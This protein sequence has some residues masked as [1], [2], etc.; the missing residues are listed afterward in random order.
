MRHIT[1]TV[2]RKIDLPQMARQSSAAELEHKV[3]HRSS[4]ASEMVAVPPLTFGAL[5]AER[6]EM[7]EEPAGIGWRESEYSSFSPSVFTM[8]DVVVHGSSGIVTY[9]DKFIGD[10][11]EHTD[12]EADGY[13][14]C[15]DGI[16][17]RVREAEPLSCRHISLLAGGAGNF[18]HGLMD[19]VA[20]LSM[21][22]DDLF[23]DGTGILVPG[24]AAAAIETLTAWKPGVRI[25]CV[26]D[27]ETLRV[28]RLVL[29]STVKGQAAYHPCICRLFDGVAAA[30]SRGSGFGDLRRVYIDR[31]GAALR[32]LVNEDELVVA[33]A[34]LGI[35]AVRLEDFSVG[36]QIEMF[37]D[38][39]LI[40]AP[41]GAGLTNLV[42][43]RP[44]CVVLELLMDAYVNWSFRR[45]AAVR[46]V[47]Y[48][49]I[50]GRAIGVWTERSPAVHGMSWVISVGH[51]VAAV[52]DI[53]NL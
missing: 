44:G 9:A 39:E 40:V 4:L 29:P 5:F 3:C 36:E 37:Q 7:R 48:D 23:E 20:R 24:R 13:R 51:V 22:A 49:C 42:Y 21:V 11:L 16:A 30:R 2:F 32:P 33:L 26:A 31:R 1:E 17:L 52:S 53:L 45:L 38:A 41:H 15:D 14:S 25:R 50:L 27:G 19:C 43:A 28:R 18:Y 10:T 12:P 6:W 47:Q 46:G 34:R 35:R 8:D